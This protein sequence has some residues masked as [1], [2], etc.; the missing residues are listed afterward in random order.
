MRKLTDLAIGECA[1]ID[2]FTDEELSLKLME[3]GCLPGLKLL[4]CGKA[5]LGC[6]IR[7]QLSG[8]TLSLRKEEA[9]TILIQS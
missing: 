7:I 4:M 5:P 8:S 9:A 1:C 3:M 2:S 6:P